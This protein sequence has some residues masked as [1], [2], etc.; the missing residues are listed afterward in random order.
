MSRGRG[1]GGW[2]A[3]QGRRLRRR[4]WRQRGMVTILHPLDQLEPIEGDEGAWRANGNDPK[5]D[6]VIDQPPLKA[7]WYRFSIEL[8]GLDDNELEPVLYFDYGV[9]MHEAW[10]LHLNFY[11]PG[12]R[13]HSGVVLLVRDVHHLRFDP[14]NA[15]CSFRVRNLVIAPIGRI[16]AARSMWSAV[17]SARVAGDGSKSELWRHAWS[18][19]RQP[20]G[21][22]A[23]ASWL[24][25]RYVKLGSRA[26]TYERWLRLYDRPARAAPHHEGLL[27]S[28][29][30]PTFNTPEIWLRRCLD[31]VLRQTCP[32][33]ELCIADDA[34]TEEQ[35]RRVLQEYSER[36]PRIRIT[37]RERNGHISAATNSA[38]VMARGNYV[39]LLDHD[40]ELHPQ[41]IAS[42]V[43]TLQ[44]NPQWQM[45][46]SDEDK[47]DAEG[48]RHEPY[49]KPD[50]NPDLLCAHN[51]VSHLGVYARSLLNSL[52]GFRV[53]LEGSQDWDLALR[54]S[55]HLRADQIGHIPKVLYHWRAIVGS[56]AQGV[57]QKH[58][59]HDAGRRAVVEHL[60]RCGIA[61]DVCEI[62]GMLG[63]FRVRHRLP[64]PPP[65]VSI[66]VPTRDHIDLLRRCVE[67]ILARTI[68]PDYE[69][70]V[71]DNQSV[72]PASIA[73]FASLSH[74][75]RVRVLAHDQPF[76]YS[77]INNAA[78][79]VCSSELICLLNNDTEVVGS[80][81]LEELASQAM[82]PHVGAVGAMLYYPNDTIQH[83]GVMTGIHG[84]AAHPYCGMPRGFSGQMSRAKLV[85]SMSAV[86]AACLMIRRETYLQV[87]GLDVSLTVAFND[88]DF[89]LRLRRAGFRNLWTP[90]AELY[91][92][93]SA[94]RG[95]EDTPQKRARFMCEVEFM[96]NRWGVEL[97]DDPAYNPNLT[98]SGEPFTLAFP[99]R[100]WPRPQ[101]NQPPPDAPQ[102]VAAPREA[103][104]S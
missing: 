12:A 9:G 88:I 22:H 44:R 95:N 13:H 47:I 48:R 65:R 89:C 73:Y 57:D 78:V 23:F 52:G 70:V 16:A 51:C 100:E 62:E 30:L 36:E 63:A 59:A 77:S 17:A 82:R 26:T 71:V 102:A 5:F 81:W 75:P 8:D 40:D 56:T 21:R 35:V 10:S 61:A 50:W 25:D 31:S 45:V 67:S 86:T 29:L 83:A 84:V 96:K 6:C 91:H 103:L 42:I 27:I 55:E 20:G 97:E 76:N 94:S 93:E 43:E 74:E 14:A 104:A 80:N 33:W 39:A 2:L 69:I 66:I 79:R 15:C 101:V 41:A 7:G 87:G 53:G 18:T 19:L 46:Y 24:H 92:H 49:F 60:A 3:H 11:R 34:S 90:F 64:E 68:Y 1:M 72:E 4:W 58:Y 85:Q 99:P 37:W 54:C 32:D 98:L 38:L 28:I